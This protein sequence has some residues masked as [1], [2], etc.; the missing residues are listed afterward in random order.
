INPHRQFSAIQIRYGGCKG[1]IS[2]NPDLDNAPHQLRIRQSMK[3][4]KCSHDILELCRISK[5]RP[6]YLNRQIIVLLSHRLIDD[7]TFLLLQNEH[8][9]ILS[10]SLVYP[11]RAY[12]L[13][14][15]KLSRNLFP[16]RS[17]IH[18]AQLNLIQEPFFHQ[19]IITIGKFELAQMRERTRLK[20]PKNS[21][22]NMIGIVDEYGILEYGQVFIQYTELNDDY[23]NANES[24]KTI[25]LEQKVVVTKNPCHHPG[26]IRVFT[27]V[28]VPQLRHLKDVIVFPQRGQRP[29][30]NEISGSDLDGDEYAVIWHPA[31][32]PQTPNDTPY[33]YDSQMPML[34]I[35]DRPIN[36]AD[37]Q[38]TVLDISEQSCVGKLCSL[39]LAN[40]DLNGVAHPK[41]LAIASYIAEELDAPKTGQH[42]LT[43]KQIGELQSELGNE[44]PDYFD[45]PYYKS[46]PSK[47]V[48]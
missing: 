16:L 13:L 29:H 41:T 1:V 11:Q 20:L 40:T 43:P 37:I 47:H 17:L 4:F 24:E 45:K 25:I 7:R 27:A 44:R 31:F 30:P 35:S 48:L 42:P 28:D 34:R 21:A 23:V 46:Y 32:I 10:E 18:D 12:E 22:R 33:D 14:S 39:H 3:K 2:V 6:L 5:P 38:A 9:Q 26:D 19:L 8:Q 15:E 36:R